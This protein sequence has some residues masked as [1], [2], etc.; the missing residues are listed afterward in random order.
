MA[1]KK[2]SE[3]THKIRET[4]GTQTAASKDTRAATR[5][6][7]LKDGTKRLIGPVELVGIKATTTKRDENL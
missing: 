2:L 5:G 4:E 6:L 3:K 7:V 1:N